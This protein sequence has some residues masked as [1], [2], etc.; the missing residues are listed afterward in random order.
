MP[1]KKPS[2]EQRLK[3]V[4]EQVLAKLPPNVS[5]DVTKLA[6]MGLA[7]VAGYTFAEDMLKGGTMVAA[8]I[9]DISGGDADLLPKGWGNLFGVGGQ[10]LEYLLGGGTITEDEQ[11]IIDELKLTE[12]QRFA[13]ACGVA[14]L[15]PLTAEIVKG[16]GQVVP[17]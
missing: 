8:Y 16:I 2:A 17:G 6:Q 13:F 10:V 4:M 3:G 11:K 7:G 5:V 14:A 1:K 9:T 15:T 12:E